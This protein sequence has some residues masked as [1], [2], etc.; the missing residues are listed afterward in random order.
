MIRTHLFVWTYFT[1]DQIPSPS[2]ANSDWKNAVVVQY[3]MFSQM[4]LLKC[5]SEAQRQA[6]EIHMEQG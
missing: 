3:L 6:T 4:L 1:L 5:Q 2:F